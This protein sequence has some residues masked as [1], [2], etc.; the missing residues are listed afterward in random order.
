[1]SPTVLGAPVGRVSPILARLRRE[2]RVYN[3]GTRLDPRWQTV[4]GDEAPTAE[5][6]AIVVRM[7]RQRPWTFHELTEA[8]GARRGRLS[9]VLVALQ[10]EGEP[11]VNLGTERRARWFLAS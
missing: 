2:G 5:L 9:G 7:V 10:R 3:I 1:M 6:R 4:I 8:T 11:L